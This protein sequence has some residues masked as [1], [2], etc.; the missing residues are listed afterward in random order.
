MKIEEDIGIRGKTPW[1]LNVWVLLG[2]VLVVV[3]LF[4]LAQ[5][6]IKTYGFYQ[7][8]KS[9]QAADSFIP[10]AEP[11]AEMKMNTLLAQKERDRVRQNVK[12]R[13]GDPFVGPS[14][15]VHEIVIFEDFF[16]PYCK[17]A[18]ATISELMRLRPDVKI[19]FRDYPITELHPD[20]KIAAQ[21]ARC[22]WQ[23][24]D[25]NKYLRYREFLYSTQN[26]LE[27]NLMI[28]YVSTLGLKQ[29]AFS[30]CIQQ[31]SG[32]APINRS[33]LDAES[34]GV[35]ATPVFFIDGIKVEG[36]HEASKLLELLK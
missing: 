25:L 6:A 8:A 29:S 5:F 17:M 24:G 36:V 16:C 12:G 22:V 26:N 9:G 27:T 20:A 21:A 35:T 14:D 30:T 28:Q 7:M 18:Q 13:E 33:I 2:F 19:S 34:A 10:I 31:Q 1:Y 15:A 4:G 23:Q 3:V 11:T 32:V